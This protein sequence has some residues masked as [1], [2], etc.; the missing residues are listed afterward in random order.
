MPS[1]ARRS[2]RSAATQSVRARSGHT[3][4]SRPTR[5]AQWSSR[6]RRR[7]ST[8]WRWRRTPFRAS[9]VRTW[10]ALRAATTVAADGPSGAVQ[11]ELTMAASWQEENSQVCCAGVRADVTRARDAPAAARAYSRGGGEGTCGQDREH[12]FA[13]VRVML[14]PQ[15]QLQLH[16]RKNRLTRGRRAGN[17]STRS[18]ASASSRSARHVQHLSGYISMQ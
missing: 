13:S 4:S 6:P 8:C 12:P 10:T 16:N 1:S 14:P 18:R 9:F 2:T 15:P 3:P 11:R 7:R 17:A 5:R